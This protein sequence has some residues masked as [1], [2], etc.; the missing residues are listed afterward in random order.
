MSRIGHVKNRNELTKELTTSYKK[1]LLNVEKTIKIATSVL[2]EFPKSGVDGAP[3]EVEVL[4]KNEGLAASAGLLAPKLNDEFVDS[5]LEAPK[6]I[7]AGFDES[8]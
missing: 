1:N 2:V 7:I 6:A 8:P 3:C 5:V 4:P